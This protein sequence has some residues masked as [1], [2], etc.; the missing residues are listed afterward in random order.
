MRSNVD[1]VRGMWDE[2]NRDGERAFPRFFSPDYVRHTFAK[3]FGRDE[4]ARIVEN[5]RLGFQDLKTTILEVV[6]EG[7][8]VAHRW[9]TVG[10]HSGSYLA[11]PPTGRRVTAMGITISR[12]EDGLIVEDWASWNEVSVLHSLG[13]MPV[14]F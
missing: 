4:F 10:T 14:D 2:L 6:V 7:D 12:F 5:R 3:S 1:V 8:R 13:V 11:I 9:E